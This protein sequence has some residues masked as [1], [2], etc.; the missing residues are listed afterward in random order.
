MKKV[1]LITGANGMLAQHL[2]AFL[3]S[4]YTLRFLTRHVKQSNDYLWN[5]EQGYIDPK[6]LQNLHGIIHLAGAPIANKR[7]TKKRKELIV[8]SRVASAELI[9]DQL[10]AH[11][12]CIDT[13][14]SAS[15]TGYYGATTSTAILTEESPSGTDFLSEVCQQWENVAHAFKTHKVA[16]NISIVR[17]GVILSKKGGILNKLV[18]SIRYGLGAA[19]G[20]GEQFIP[21]IHIQD[22]SGI[23][24]FLLRHPELSGSYNAVA[25]D[26]ATNYMFTAKIAKQLHKKIRLPNIPKFVLRWWFGEANVLIT[27]GTR[28]ASKKIQ[29]QGFR[30]N[31]KHLDDALN[32]VL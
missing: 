23:F 4:E 14:I 29:Q 24:E 26:H 25:P 31:Y 10:I 21:W 30:F 28:I 20:T 9:L 5:I 15:A 11:E 8:S 7:W 22:L 27:E 18:P 3:A 1:I 2:G 32:D 16:N 19:I 13:F 6:A 12:L 17:L